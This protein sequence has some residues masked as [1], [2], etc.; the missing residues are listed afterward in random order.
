MEGVVTAVRD[1]LVGSV[2]LTQSGTTLTVEDP[3]EF[4]EAGTLQIGDETENYTVVDD[5]LILDSALSG[6]YAADDPV[7]V[8]P[9]QT[10]RN[11]LVLE[12]G[13]DEEV[14]AV[15][16]HN[17][18]ALLSSG[19][20]DGGELVACE[21]V[22]DELQVVDVV[23]RKP[24][25]DGEFVDTPYDDLP[26]TSVTLGTSYTVTAEQVKVTPEFDAVA[27][28]TFNVTVKVA[29][30]TTAYVSL[31][32]DGVQ[33]GTERYAAQDGS[34]AGLY[35]PVTGTVQVAMSA[36]QAYVLEV[37]GKRTGPGACSI[38]GSKTGGI[39]YIL[40]AG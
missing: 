20:R 18:H 25:I 21:V 28:V 36:G 35:F 31:M 11:A 10:E 9:P 39:G 23:A 34:N 22:G 12:A 15:V 1:H 40:F 2:L 27:L 14:E 8:Y 37:A 4:G 3:D 7:L 30:T 5:E 19:T 26:I 16:P 24:E 13:S 29:A 38:E 6:T 17:L 33:T 32:V